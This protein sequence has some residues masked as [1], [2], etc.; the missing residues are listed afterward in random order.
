MYIPLKKVDCHVSF[1]AYIFQPDLC[2]AQR[3]AKAYTCEAKHHL[4]IAFLQLGRFY[5]PNKPTMLYFHGWTG[6]GGG[7]EK[8]RLVFVDFFWVKLKG[9]GRFFSWKQ[10]F[11]LTLELISRKVYKVLLYWWF[12]GKNMVNSK[13]GDI[14]N[15]NPWAVFFLSSCRFPSPRFKKSQPKDLQHL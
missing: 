11:F 4:E 5:D 6:Q 9:S 12:H 3:F 15:C 8:K 1:Q 10:L 13:T 14:F 2:V 7:L